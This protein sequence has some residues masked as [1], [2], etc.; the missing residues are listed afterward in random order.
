MLLYKFIMPVLFTT[1]CSIVSA[2]NIKAEKD[3]I[4]AKSADWNNQQQELKFDLYSPTSSVDLP[5]V[6]FMH[7]GG[8]MN[9]DKS[10]LESFC[11]KLAAKGFVVANV[12]YRLGFDT[13]ESKRNVGIIMACYRAVQDQDAALRFLVDHAKEYHI[14][15]SNIFVSGESAGAVT[16]LDN[17]FIMQTEWDS[18]FPMLHEQ[19]GAK[20]GSGNKLLNRYSIKGIISMWGGIDTNYIS[21]A[22]SKA[23][24]ILLIQSKADE[25]IPFEHAKNQNKLYS[26]MFG[27][28]DI[29]KRYNNNGSCATL[30][31]TKN[32][33]HFFGFSQHYVAAAVQQFVNSVIEGRCK[34]RSEENKG[35]NDSINFGRYE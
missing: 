12:N 21:A 31:Y 35:E 6:L 22:E 29:A 16:C 25:V 33:R 26:Y 18:L 30:L 20:E 11:L 9:G 24:P 27:S 13:T 19:L 2:Q 28:Y 3:I 32:A 4:Y 10:G 23:I 8:F 15:T 17:G 7:G 34:S 5:L 1:L 14:D